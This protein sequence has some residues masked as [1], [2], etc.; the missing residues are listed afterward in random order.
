MR[1]GWLLPLPIPALTA[2]D[3]WITDYYLLRPANPPDKSSSPKLIPEAERIA[4][5][6]G[7]AH[8]F[9]SK[10][11]D[12]AGTSSFCRQWDG[13]VEVC[14]L[15]CWDKPVKYVLRSAP[16]HDNFLSLEFHHGLGFSRHDS[17]IHVRDDLMNALQTRLQLAK[18]DSNGR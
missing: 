6:F 9:S 2:C 15:R 11:C 18:I 7:R 14:G 17:A 13:T 8:G 1:Y 5:D 16:N 4:E 12:N 3:H 10:N